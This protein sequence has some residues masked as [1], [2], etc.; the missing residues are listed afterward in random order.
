[1]KIELTCPE[2]HSTIRVDDVHTGKQVCCPVCSRITQIPIKGEV[3]DRPPTQPIDISIVGQG[4]SKNRNSGRSDKAPLLD[5]YLMLAFVWGIASVVC[6]F[7]CC[8]VGPFVSVALSF[9]GMF[10]VIKARSRFR[11]TA[12]LINLCGLLIAIVLI[13]F[14][15]WDFLF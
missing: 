10:N 13:T 9:I 1:M 14:S 5:Q 8:F 15:F 11:K 4:D 3:V 2:C 7:F 12:L 6:N